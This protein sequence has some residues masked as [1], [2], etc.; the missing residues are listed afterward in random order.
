M[1]I[2]RLFEI[3]YLLLD[4]KTITARELAAHF[5]VSVRT[6]LRDVETLCEA[7]IPIYTQ[8][9]KGGGISILDHFILNKTAISDE[10]Q[11]QILFA[12]QSLSTTEQLETDG[13]LSK[14]RAFFHKTD[15][16]WIEVD[17]SRWGNR[18]QDKEQFETLKQAILERKPLTFTYIDAFGRT[19]FRKIYPVK[20]AF[21]AKA[22]YLQGY[23]L[24]KQDYRTFKVS[25][26]LSTKMSAEQY[27]DILPAAPAIEPKEMYSD[28]VVSLKLK[29]S[30][31]VTHRIY[32]E[33]TKSNVIQ[34][35]AGETIVSI[36]LPE[37]PWLYGY[38]LSFGTHV[39]VI[40]PEHVRA[41]LIQEAKKIINSYS[42]GETQADFSDS[43]I[44][45]E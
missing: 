41:Q 31:Q 9:G 43:S 44:Y 22:W 8:Q 10:E 30:P 18:E 12:L 45:A 33:F 17:F 14:L 1:Q 19:T 26:M 29:F 34:N 13:I 23:C 16:N 3:V 5:E 35:E 38:L 37:D 25:R 15:S 7:G 4:K 28:S 6:I 32:D 40:E 39:Q 2:H 42:S 11:N 20:L 27:P 24:E 36:D 21:K